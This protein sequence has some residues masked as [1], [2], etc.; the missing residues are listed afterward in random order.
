MCGLSLKH[1]G[2]NVVIVEQ[3]ADDRKSHMAGIGLAPSAVDFLR[4]HDRLES[5]FAHKIDCIK[6]I[7]KDNRLRILATGRRDI[8]SWD[9]LY[10]RLRSNFDGFPSTYYTSA[11]Q[12][13]VTDGTATYLSNTSVLDV[14]RTDPT[15]SR[16][17]VAVRNSHTRDV[18]H[19][20]A[21][22]VIGADGPDSLIRAKY[23]PSVRR[24]YAGYVAWRGTVSERDLSKATWN[25]LEDSIVN[26]MM[27][28]HHIIVYT[29]P[30]KDGSLEPGE[31]LINFCWYTNE[32]P[33]SLENIMKDKVDGHRHRSTVPAGRVQDSVWASRLQ[34]ARNE[35][36]PA[37][38]LE[39]VTKIQ[40]PFIQII[41]DFPPSR[42]VFENGQVL[43][44]GDALT[45][46][47]PHAGLSSAKSAYHSLAI[48]DYVCGKISIQEWEDRV[49]RYSYLYWAQGVWWGAFY[50][51]SMSTALI[52]A[53]KYWSYKAWYN[54]ALWWK[55]RVVTADKG[56]PLGDEF[57]V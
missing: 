27:N 18:F 48:E 3:D 43:L 20:E 6:T 1:V 53:V 28:R 15:N 8:T 17:T 25:A 44:M 14:S 39:I 5:V 49:L 32:T 11:P 54:L 41:S 52:P 55:T 36:L 16:L 37:A 23:Q 35:P 56:T 10:Y 21:D 57:T 12:G 13:A 45:L 51:E 31:R 26:N 4:R 42:G 50:Q 33:Q 22:L 2:C 38:F 24:R 40:N 30:G 7:G 9:A 29:I 46:V 47:R 19:M 34:H